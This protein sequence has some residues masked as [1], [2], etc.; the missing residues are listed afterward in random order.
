LRRW[1]RISGR[2]V[3]HGTFAEINA[4]VNAAV[5]ALVGNAMAGVTMPASGPDLPLPSANEN[6]A[7]AGAA[8][9][10]DVHVKI[11]HDGSIATAITAKGRSVGKP[12]VETPMQPHAHELLAR[13][14]ADGGR[15]S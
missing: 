14:D 8:G 11:S 10:V 12:R 6:A 13:R 1:S 5:N 2:C 9:K 15:A 3:A 7:A 4:Q